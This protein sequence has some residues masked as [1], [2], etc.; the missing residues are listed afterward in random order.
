MFSVPQSTPEHND[1]RYVVWHLGLNVFQLFL[2]FTTFLRWQSVT[3]EKV[4][5]DVPTNSSYLQLVNSNP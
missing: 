3:T 5:V 1:L 4:D 2:N